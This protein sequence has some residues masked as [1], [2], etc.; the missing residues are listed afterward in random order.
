MLMAISAKEFPIAAVRRVVIVVAVF[1][2]D[3]QQLKIAL[4]ERARTSAAHPR[5]KLESL[6]AIAGEPFIGVAPRVND[7]LVQPVIFFC[8][9]VSLSVGG[10]QFVRHLQ[11]VDQYKLARDQRVPH[12]LG[13]R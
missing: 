10:R 13:F 6:R 8:H 2:M 11:A 12:S 7:Y 1:V 4:V 5:I 9:R 3:F